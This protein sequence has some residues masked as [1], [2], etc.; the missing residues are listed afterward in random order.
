MLE[1]ILDQKMQVGMHAVHI[2]QVVQSYLAP[3]DP[4][5]DFHVHSMVLPSVD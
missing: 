1:R 2:L 5:E 4:V 3:L